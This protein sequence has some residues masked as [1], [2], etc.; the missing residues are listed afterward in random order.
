MRFGPIVLILV[1]VVFLAINLGAFQMRQLMD[2]L[3]TW[4]PAILIVV[5]VI[6]LLGKGARK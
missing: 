4:W 1:G 2:L 6:G 3:H 5:G